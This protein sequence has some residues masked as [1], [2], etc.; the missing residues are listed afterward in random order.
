[1]RGA[2]ACCGGEARERERGMLGS[3]GWALAFDGSGLYCS[4]AARWGVVRRT[5][6]LGGGRL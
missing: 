4:H 3:G 6:R 5:G 2:G 1:M